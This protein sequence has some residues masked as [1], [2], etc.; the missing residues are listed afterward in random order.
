MA[1]GFHGFHVIV[2]TMLPDRLLV[3]RHAPATSRR[4]SISASRRRPGTGT[5]STWCGCSC[6]SASTGGAPGGAGT[7]HCA[8]R[9]H[10]VA[11]GARSCRPRRLAAGLLLRCPRCGE[12]HLSKGSLTVATLRG[13]G[14][15]LAPMTPAMGRRFLSPHFHPGRGS[16]SSLGWS[17]EFHHSR[18]RSGPCRARGPGPVCSAARLRLLRPRKALMI[19]AGADTVPSR[20]R[21]GGARQDAPALSPRP[22]AR[23]SFADPRRRSRCLARHL[24]ARAAHLEDALDRPHAAAHHGRRRRSSPTFCAGDPPRRIRSL[25]S[26]GTFLHDRSCTCRARLRS[27]VGF[28]VVTPFRP[29]DGRIVLV[30]RGWVPQSAD[31]ARRAE[32]QLPGTVDVTASCGPTRTAAVHA[33]QRARAQCLVLCRPA[34]DGSRPAPARSAPPSYSKPMP[35]ANPGGLPMGGQTRRDLPNDHL[36]Y[37]IT[38][39][40]HCRGAVASISPSAAGPPRRRRGS[41]LT[42]N[43][44]LRPTRTRFAALSAFNRG[45]DAA[46]GLGDDDAAGRREARAEQLA[47]LKVVAHGLMTAPEVA[48]C[49][50]GRRGARASTLARGQPARDAAPWAH[51]RAAGRRWSRRC[52]A[53]PRPARWPGA[54]RGRPATSPLLPRFREVLAWCA[55]R[56]RRRRRRSAR[57]P[58]TRCSTNTSRTAA[59][60]R[61]TRC[62]PTSRL[63]ARLARPRAGA[64]GGAARRRCAGRPVPGRRSSASSA[65]S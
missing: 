22:A 58:T 25:D 30:D 29:M 15:D 55:R 14:L 48:D 10:E 44:R 57:R 21:R 3:P 23:P 54:R 60:Q 32:G 51:A 42:A 33:R 38:W 27:N 46:L 1:T 6:S 20:D 5:S 40:L 47:M 13:C 2:G 52:R 11:R 12:G 39:F 62:S 43:D 19:R 41:R 49:W 63:P 45:R 34:G 36:Q 26:P 9:I 56:R 53:P 28:Q 50:R 24:A 37:A 65:S 16:S 18:R 4:S 17:T 61:S 59:P 35:R 7:S 8:R 64:P 31:P